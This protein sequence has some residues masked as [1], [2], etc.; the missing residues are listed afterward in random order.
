MRIFNL[1]C[2]R[3][4]A[5][6]SAILDGHIILSADLAQRNHFPAIDILRSRSRLMDVVA[7]RSHRQNAARIRDLMARYESIELLLR[8]GEYKHGADARADEALDRH[9]RIEQFLRQASDEYF[10]LSETKLQLQEL[11]S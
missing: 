5:R 7:S 2:W 9:D 4:L 1:S 3:S 10:G 11:L 6:C 8:V